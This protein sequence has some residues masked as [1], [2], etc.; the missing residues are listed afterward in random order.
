MMDVGMLENPTAAVRRNMETMP[1]GTEGQKVLQL[2]L[3]HSESM[4]GLGH[5][6]RKN[7]P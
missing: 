7:A 1:F 2:C 3:D 4:P 5:K 6:A